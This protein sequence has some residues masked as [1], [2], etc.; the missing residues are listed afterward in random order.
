VKAT[1]ERAIEASVVFVR[2]ALVGLVCVGCT[3]PQSDAGRTA[4]L[5][6]SNHLRRAALF[7]REAITEQPRYPSSLNEIYADV[8]NRSLFVCPA[9]GHKAGKMTEIESWSDYIFVAKL[10]DVLNDPRVPVLIC[11]PENHKGGF[12]LVMNLDGSVDEVSPN[13]VKQLVGTPWL[14][15][16]NAPSAEVQRL[17]RILIVRVPKRL[18]GT[19]TNVYRASPNKNL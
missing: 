6:C 14:R 5:Q 18:E 13:L 8:T 9:T 15:A 16:T 7:L 10:P 17:Q 4:E 11:P 3:Q 19:Y 1:K 12:G 2:F